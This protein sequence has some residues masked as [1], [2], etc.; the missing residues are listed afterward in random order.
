MGTR[1]LTEVIMSLSGNTDKV[2][3]APIKLAKPNG[4]TGGARE[5]QGN[6]FGKESFRSKIPNEAF[7][8][9]YDKINW[10]KSND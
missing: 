2:T 1:Q 4:H 7:K 5:R 8:S 6:N 9:G 10:G 3:K